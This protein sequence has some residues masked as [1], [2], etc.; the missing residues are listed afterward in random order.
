MDTVTHA[1]TR[2]LLTWIASRPRT[3]AETMEARRSTCPRQSVRED[4]VGDGLI[5]VSRRIAG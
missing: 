3:Y 4:A 2:E 1:L 5:Q